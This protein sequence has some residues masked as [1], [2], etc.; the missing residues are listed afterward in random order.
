MR[1]ANGWQ[2]SLTR[3]LA[4]AW[5]ADLTREFPAAAMLSVELGL[6]LL[7]R[8][9]PG[10]PARDAWTLFGGYPY[11]EAAGH[12]RNPEE[13]EMIAKMAET[14]RGLA[15]ARKRKLDKDGHGVD[16]D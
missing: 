4:D 14:W 7:A 1:S 15:E 2:R 3:Q 9:L 6:Y 12:A 5:P 11:A 13:R 10:R 8:V 16:A